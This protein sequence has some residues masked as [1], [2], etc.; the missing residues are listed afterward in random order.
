MSDHDDFV[1]GFITAAAVICWALR[2]YEWQWRQWYG[3]RLR[4][5]R[6]HTT[7]HARASIELFF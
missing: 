5:H 1:V 3:C 6:E 7:K 2:I 4:L